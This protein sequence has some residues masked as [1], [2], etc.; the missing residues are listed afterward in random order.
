VSVAALDLTGIFPP[1]TTPFDDGGGCDLAG[2]RRNLRG[3]GAAPLAG[4]VVLGSNGEF[5]HL[6][7]AEKE[8]VIAAAVEEAGGRPVLAQVAEGSL[9]ETVLLARRAAELGAAGV[10]AVTPHYYRAAMSERVLIDH[11]RAL[12]DAS[13][14]PVLLYSIPQNTGVN[15][16]PAVVAACAEHP[17][18]VG[19]KDSG[20]NLG[21][22]AESVQA[23]AAVRE[24]FAVLNGSSAMVVAAF[25]AGARGAVLA[26]ADALPFEIC[27]L[28]ELCR[29]GRWTEAFELEARLRPVLRHMSR[30]GVAGTKLA[31][32]L[33]GFR[34]GEPRAPLRP[35]PAAEREVLAEALRTAG[36][37]RW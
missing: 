5:P 28:W 1:L 25:A 21:Q 31:M 26:A 10:L 2:L 14:V 8:A 37:V 6:T 19:I 13:P 34:G 32:D 18:I 30:L 12:A 15:C 27:D 11:Y 9:R 20:A 16:T 33:M 7:R 24:G 17:N 22:L 36:L 3:Y 29:Q 23:A 4:Y 35:A